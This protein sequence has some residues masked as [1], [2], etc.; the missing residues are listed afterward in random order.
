MSHLK[1]SGYRQLVLGALV[2]ALG[3]SNLLLAFPAQA[4]T[5]SPVRLELAADP[6][7]TIEGEFQI[8]N[9]QKEDL[10]FYTQPENFEAKDETGNPKFVG[11]K[12]GLATWIKV[13]SSVSVPAGERVK[14]P[15]TVSIPKEVE[16]GGYFSAIFL[17]TT[18]PV[19]TTGGEINIG[20]RLGPLVFLRVNGNLQE[21]VSILQFATKNQQRW[22][23]SLPVELFY[24]FQNSGADRVKPLGSIVI[25]NSFGLTSKTINANKTEGSVLPQSIRRF[26]LAWIDGNGGEQE[27]K[28]LP[29]SRQPAG[30]FA[31]AKYQW[32]Y[33]ALGMYTANLA[34]QY[35]Q[36]QAQSAK[37]SFVF[38]IFPWQLMLLILGAIII[39][40]V[41]LRFLLKRYNNWV[42]AKSKNG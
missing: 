29:A 21:N 4:A 27:I 3:F 31:A 28:D 9:E 15:F 23:N 5:I 36:D 35:G 6:G 25:K 24:R 14:I 20:S 17:R 19:E 26:E 32:D 11:A 16:P 39:V 30:F 33:F 40:F 2:I 34:L 18:P 8:Y 22:F 7:T 37:A 10:V 12:D 41:V 42:I 1:F 38:F 13:R